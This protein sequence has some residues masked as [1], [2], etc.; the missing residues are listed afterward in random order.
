[1]TL[2]R[3]RRVAA[4]RRWSA[5]LPHNRVRRAVIR[6]ASGRRVGYGPAVPLPEP[7]LPA[8]ACRAVTRPSCRV[9]VELDG[10][11]GDDLRRLQEAY[12]LARRPRPTAVEVGPLP[13]ST[14]EVG[15]WLTAIGGGG[16]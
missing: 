1:L 3:R 6:D 14:A 13:V 8:V 2:D 10:P 4:W 9:E 11:S 5:K 16:R 7:P 12:R 15:E